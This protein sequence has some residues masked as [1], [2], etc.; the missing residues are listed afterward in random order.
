[1]RIQVKAGTSRLVTGSHPWRRFVIP[2]RKITG[3]PS[4]ATS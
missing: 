1:M 3:G 2:C 4:P